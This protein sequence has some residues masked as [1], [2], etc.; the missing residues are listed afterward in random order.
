MSGIIDLNIYDIFMYNGLIFTLINNN[1]TIVKLQNKHS[2]KLN[3]I[4]HFM[5]RLLFIQ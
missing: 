2:W 1:Q 3:I 5:F 4:T